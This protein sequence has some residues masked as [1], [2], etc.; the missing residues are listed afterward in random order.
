[1]N[2][3]SISATKA[4]LLRQRRTK[5]S[6]MLRD[7]PRTVKI[8]NYFSKFLFNDL[9]KTPYTVVYVIPNLNHVDLDFYLFILMLLQ[10]HNQ[11]SSFIPVR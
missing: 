7:S 4:P 8:Q 11:D 3:Q 5:A 2:N 10:L 9:Y 1:M 6:A